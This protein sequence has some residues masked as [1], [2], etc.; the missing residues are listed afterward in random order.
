MKCRNVWLGAWPLARLLI[1]VLFVIHT[2]ETL[3]LRANIKSTKTSC[4]TSHEA[5][6]QTSLNVFQ[7][8]I[9]RFVATVRGGGAVD[10]LRS[11]PCC[12][13]IINGVFNAFNDRPDAQC[14]SC[15]A[16]ERH[17]RVCAVLGGPPPN[18]AAS[19]KSSGW[20]SVPASHQRPFRLLSFGPQPQ[21]ERELTNM[22]GVLDHI[23]LDSFA[24]GYKYSGMTLQADV[25]DLSFPDSF[26]DGIIILHVLEHVPR[27][28]DAVNEIGR[29]IRKDT[30]WALIEVPCW[31]LK[32]G[33]KDCR[34]DT[35]E[36][37]HECAGQHDHVWK[38]D[39]EDFARVLKSHNLK[40]SKIFETAD[41]LPQDV[42]NTMAL[43]E[44]WMPLLFCTAA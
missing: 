34:L 29:V 23:S 30:G 26:A 21:M 31:N 18:V 17:R 33:T 32:A 16:L 7:T 1:V 37:R 19:R 43:K 40:C 28:H 6:S 5:E 9:Q 27:L 14:P 11:C 24:P 2:W 41:W 35:P 12:G 8:R 3:W 22:T 44:Q 10:S 38:F 25:S 4:H 36:Q 13:S 15:H 39:C 20:F 42:R